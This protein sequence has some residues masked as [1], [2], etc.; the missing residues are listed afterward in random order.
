MIAIADIPQ[1]NGQILMKIVGSEAKNAS[2]GIFSSG[3]HTSY[4]IVGRDSLGE[5]DVYRRYKEF[6]T[7][8]DVLYRRY[9]GI[10]IPPIPPK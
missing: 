7:F 5:I 8:R 1:N 2:S 9:P 10:Y 4:H 3:K 6:F